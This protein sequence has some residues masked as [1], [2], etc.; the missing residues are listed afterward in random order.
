[1]NKLNAWML[2]AAVALAACGKESPTPAE[3][4]T[5]APAP[6]SAAV[7]EAPTAPA[8]AAQAEAVS[9][10]GEK[11]ES[12]GSATSPI[13]SAIAATTPAPP[14]GD[15]GRWKEGENFTRY[16]VAQPV[17]TP[18]GKV[19]VVEGFWYGCGHCYS[20][21]P[22]VDSWEKA[23]PDWIV[24]RRLPVIWNEVTREDA[25]LFYTIEA[26]GLTDKLHAEVFREIHARKRP[27][28]AIRNG[29]V[30]R[31]A[32]EKAA[33]EF[34]L[35]NGVSAADFEK[36]YRT[37]STENKLRQAENL[38]RRYLL[39]HTPMF[40][41]HGKYLTDAEMA[42][43]LDQLFQLVSDLAAREHDAS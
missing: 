34:M 8:P 21:E 30:D 40:V 10:D 19:E 24:L 12:A 29:R 41:V 27:I 36:Q 33:R 38:S 18:P 6:E 32:T 39:D 22:R 25:R 43:G 23:K 2:A 4:V 42:G 16:P 37:F 28:T 31:A 11:V 3:P 15:L 7:A 5:E 17:S 13:A 9:P 26:L 1:M 14:Q 35:A 20:L